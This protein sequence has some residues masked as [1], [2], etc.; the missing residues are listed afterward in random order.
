LELKIRNKN[1]SLLCIIL[2]NAKTH[3]PAMS[4]FK[5]KCSKYFGSL[6]NVELDPRPEDLSFDEAADTKIPFGKYRGSTIGHLVRSRE[7]RD[8]LRYLM[9]WDGLRLP[10]K[11]AIIRMLDAFEEYTE[12]VNALREA[13]RQMNS[14]R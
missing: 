6:D 2:F 5:V 14:H 7:S 3:T 11:N 13:E 1:D 9:K 10:I 4:D 12:G 8:Y